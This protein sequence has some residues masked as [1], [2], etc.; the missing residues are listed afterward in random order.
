LP[1][2]HFEKLLEETCP[3]H[4]YPVKHKLRDCGMMKNFMTSRS[5]TRGMEVD[6]VPD[7]G[8]ATTFP[9]E[10]VVMM[11]YDGRTSPGVCHMSNLIPGTPA[12]CS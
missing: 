9:G 6:E 10:D 2:D 3:N 11:I 5:L 7:E 4:A 8:D 12:R 1:T